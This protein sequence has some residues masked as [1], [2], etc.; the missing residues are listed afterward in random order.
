MNRYA[1]RKQTPSGSINTTA[2]H[3]S[4]SYA[5]VASAQPGAKDTYTWDEVMVMDDRQQW[6]ESAEVEI[7]QLAE[8]RDT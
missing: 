6:L 1:G 7:T 3:S 2:T 8:T 5:Y 4:S